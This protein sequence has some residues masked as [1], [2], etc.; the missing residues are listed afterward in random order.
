MATVRKLKVIATN[1]VI[2][3][4]RV[5]TDKQEKSGL[6]LEAQLDLCRK[7]AEQLGLEIIGEFQEMIS[8]KCDR[9]FFRQRS[10]SGK[11]FYPM[12]TLYQHFVLMDMTETKEICTVYLGTSSKDNDYT[13]YEDGNVKRYY[14]ENMW[15]HSLTEWLKAE[16]LGNNIKEALFNKCPEEM[17]EKAK[18]LLYP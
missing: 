13:L 10:D 4:C 5:S 12:L 2:I 6:G 14:D 9:V 15:K 11:T 3:Y 7:V 17:K 1:T 8:G 18:S 16:S